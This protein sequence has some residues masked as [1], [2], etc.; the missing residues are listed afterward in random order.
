MKAEFVTL[1]INDDLLLMG[2][3]ETR[4]P[5]HEKIINENKRDSS[6]ATR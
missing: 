3:G 1:G 2:D 4:K 6:N 5:S